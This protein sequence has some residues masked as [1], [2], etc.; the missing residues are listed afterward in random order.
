MLLALLLA[1][2]APAAPACPAAPASLPPEYA[3]WSAGGSLAAGAG[4][5]GAPVLAIG[6]GA[7][8]TLPAGD[9]FAPAA[10]LT[11]PAAHAG[12]L[13]FEVASAGRYRVAMSAGLWVDV[14]ANHSTRDTAGHGH[15]PDCTALKKWVEWELTPGRYLLQLSGE[16]A[17]V[18]VELV[19]VG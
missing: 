5:A 15:G 9:A 4:S 3:G 10:P 6:R 14:V 12:L 17:S 1:Q 2:A 13:A 8:V 19:K 11:R 18:Q 16:P 7:R